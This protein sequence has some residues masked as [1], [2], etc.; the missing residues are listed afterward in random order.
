MEKAW[1]RSGNDIGMRLP[2]R[3]MPIYVLCAAVCLWAA[4]CASAD[5]LLMSY[6]LLM[7]DEG[8]DGTIRAVV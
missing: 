1:W 3:S 7:F 6:W 8:Q 2:S 5:F 4:S